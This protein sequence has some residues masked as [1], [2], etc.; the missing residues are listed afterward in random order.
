MAV[1]QLAAEV[2]VRL[3]C[4]Q[5]VAVEEGRPLQVAAVEEERRPP[6]EEGEPAGEALHSYQEG[7]GAGGGEAL[8]W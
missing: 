5:V 7:A 6:E 3:P 8:K 4:L 2:A 1:R